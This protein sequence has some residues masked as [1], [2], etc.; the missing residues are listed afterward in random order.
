[1]TNHIRLVGF[2]PIRANSR[3][4]ERREILEIER[5]RERKRE[6]LRYSVRDPSINQSGYQKESSNVSSHQSVSKNCSL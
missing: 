2:C 5:E 1:M 6:K 3:Y 4:A